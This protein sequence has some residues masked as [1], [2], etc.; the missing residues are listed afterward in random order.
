MATT[1]PASSPASTALAPAVPTQT[2][3]S[4]KLMGDRRS[5]R[6]SFLHGE[7]PS[8]GKY[9][10]EYDLKYDPECDLEDDIEELYSKAQTSG[11]SVSPRL[12]SG[13]SGILW[14][15]VGRTPLNIPKS[16]P[17]ARQLGLSRK[18]HTQPRTLSAVNLVQHTATLERQLEEAGPATRKSQRQVARLLTESPR[19]TQAAGGVKG[20]LRGCLEGV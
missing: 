3:S 12:P 8:E 17:R 11:S 19:L 13:G 5:R 6:A 7:R 20:M 10:P 15:P 2:S 9:D 4:C 1:A 14:T 18:G 16:Y